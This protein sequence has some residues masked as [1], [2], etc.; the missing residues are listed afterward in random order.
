MSVYIYSVLVVLAL[1]LILFIG[2]LIQK[3]REE[4]RRRKEMELLSAQ[5]RLEE[6][7]EKLANLRKVLYEIENQLTTNKHYHATKKE[8]LIQVAKRLKDV[9]EEKAEIQRAIDN[10]APSEQ[11]MN[12]FNNRLKLNREKLVEL[13]GEAQDLK[14]DVDRYSREAAENEQ[15]IQQLQGKIQ[16]A[17]SELEYNREMVKIKERQAKH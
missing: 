4:A 1:C 11:E 14:D 3:K 5:R 15:E 9:E 6:S 12:L 8:E 17:E 13:G 10:N 16:Q 7:R 2:L